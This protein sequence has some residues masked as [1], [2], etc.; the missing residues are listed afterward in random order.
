MRTTF[1]ISVIL[2]AALLQSAHSLSIIEPILPPSEVLEKIPIIRYERQ[3][4]DKILEHCQS[5]FNKRLN[6]EGSEDW[7]DYQNLTNLINTIL[8]KGVDD[9]L[10]VLC[11]ARTM[12]YQ[13]LG[14]IYSACISRFYLLEHGFSQKAAVAYVEIFKELEFMCTGGI[15]QSIN[16]WDCIMEW[17]M[18]SDETYNKCLDQYQE[19]ITTDPSQTCRAAL[20]MALCARMPYTVHCGLEVGWW[21]C[22]RVRIAL[23]IDNYCPQM[24]CYFEL[25][26]SSQQISTKKVYSASNPYFMDHRKQALFAWLGRH[27]N[28]RLKR[29]K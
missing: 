17:K 9:G 11:N 18:T 26:P 23:D 19:T 20:S 2:L 21:E 8:Q 13:C 3:C 29:K 24:N 4:N 15:L 28:E 10:L 7:H 5:A 22:E 14:A 25:V 27:S 12:F 6:I 1:G 16:H